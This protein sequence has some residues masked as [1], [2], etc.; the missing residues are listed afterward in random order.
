MRNFNLQHKWNNYYDDDVSG[1]AITNG[2]E[3]PFTEETFACN[4]TLM[5]KITKF[6]CAKLTFDKIIEWNE[7]SKRLTA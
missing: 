5:A 3:I 7:T 4:N 6:N 2:Q 1:K